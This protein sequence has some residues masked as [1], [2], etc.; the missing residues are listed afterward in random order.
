MSSIFND[1]FT[2]AARAFP[3]MCASDEFHFLP[4]AQGAADHSH[5][6]DDLDTETMGANLQA[7]DD[8]RRRFRKGWQG[9]ESLEG[10]T[11]FR[12]AELSAT[13][14]LVEFGQARPWLFSPLL[15]L[16]IALIGL[17]HALSKPA[18][19]Q[20]SRQDRAYARL[21]EIP[22][23]LRQC[24]ANVRTAPQDD[25]LAAREVAKAGER[26]I[27]ALENGPL[28][29]RQG[30]GKTF[31]RVYRG[32]GSF[33]AHLE[34][35]IMP[36]PADALGGPDAATILGR[37]FGSEK[38]PAEVFGLAEA[39]RRREMEA[40]GALGR[41]LGGN[42]LDLYNEYEPD[43]AGDLG[44]VYESEID[45]LRAFFKDQDFPGMEH[46]GPVAF[47]ETP[48]YL[49]PVRSSASFAAAYGPLGTGE[50]S[51]FYI[52]PGTTSDRDAASGALLNRR[53]IR[54]T[55]F[56]AAHETYPGHHLLDC[57][58]RSLENPV[59]RQIENALFYEGWA[60]FG[61]SLVLELGYEDSPFHR[62]VFHK[63]GLWRAARCMADLGM[64]LGEITPAQGADLL[65]Q[66]GFSDDEARDQIRRFGLKPGYQACY[67]L[68]RL[69]IE[70]LRRE[71]YSGKDVRSF[72]R[73]L[74]AGGEL[75]PF[76]AREHL[77]S[78][79]MEENE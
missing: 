32:I 19:S 10:A 37:V 58:R 31:E 55:P 4:R 5:L 59:R 49:R 13:S 75:P 48:A 8:F 56:L 21:G 38:T 72:C 27:R 33:K 61:E 73:D 69:E 15:Y 50:E 7:L 64:A 30:A 35:K 39:E 23:L 70:A 65:S 68:G 14:A 77:R 79:T 34:T 57:A 47:A 74:L 36:S 17:D 2:F 46:D 44:R 71:F 54:E 12:M 22:R 62:L 16:K 43:T 18:E 66:A 45:Q 51:F 29:K 3:V 53:L 28:G 6:L 76:L 41:E 78:A 25:R 20:K 67:L 24:M 52:S 26:W 40:L 1:Y 11:D 42:W 60:T 63:R 9:A